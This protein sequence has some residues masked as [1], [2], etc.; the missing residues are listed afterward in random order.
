MYGTNKTYA[1]AGNILYQSI[2]VLILREA[3]QQSREVKVTHVE[4]PIKVISGNWNQDRG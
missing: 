1:D 3:S 4:D 2:C